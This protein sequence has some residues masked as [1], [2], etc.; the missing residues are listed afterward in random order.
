[1]FAY[2]DYSCNPK[3]MMAMARLLP[4]L[5]ERGPSLI[6]LLDYHATTEQVIES[7][8][9]GIPFTHFK[10]PEYGDLVSRPFFYTV[11]ILFLR[12]ILQKLRR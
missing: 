5:F 3:Q 10:S 1:M 6:G 4:R 2:L 9:L 11:I 12:G 7:K 8:S